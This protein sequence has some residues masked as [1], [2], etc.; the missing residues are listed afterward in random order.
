MTLDK[1]LSLMDK[2]VELHFPK[3]YWTDWIPREKID[4]Y[5]KDEA[6]SSGYT[7]EEFADEYETPEK[8]YKRYILSNSD[9]F[10]FQFD[11]IGE[12]EQHFHDDKSEFDPEYGRRVGAKDIMDWSAAEGA[13]NF[14]HFLVRFPANFVEDV[15]GTGNL[16][17]HLKSKLNGISSK[18]KSPGMSAG[19]IIEFFHEL[20]PNN[21]IRFTTWINDN[22]NY[23]RQ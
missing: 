23:K 15:W 4:E 17:Q 18:D 3:M 11:T 5:L 13:T 8:P 1:A 14:A 12:I 2:G 22:F 6:H 7:V 10:W 19:S 9:L 20:S 16:G 21:Q